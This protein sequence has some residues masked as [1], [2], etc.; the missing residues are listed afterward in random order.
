MKMRQDELILFIYY[1]EDKK[2]QNQVVK[3]RVLSTVNKYI[4]IFKYTNSKFKDN[5]NFRIN[6]SEFNELLQ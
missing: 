3:I 1:C 5:D 2:Y 6:F 4:F